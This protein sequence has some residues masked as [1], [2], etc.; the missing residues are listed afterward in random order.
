M[1]ARAKYSLFLLLLLSHVPISTSTRKTT[2]SSSRRRRRRRRK[3]LNEYN[4]CNSRIYRKRKTFV[5]KC[6]R[7]SF[8][9]HI[10]YETK[11]SRSQR[12]NRT[13]LLRLRRLQCE[14][15]GSVRCIISNSTIAAFRFYSRAAPVA[16]FSF[17]SHV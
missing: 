10:H 13:H 2:T 11:Q 1:G 7:N 17:P 3:T 9:H 5:S 15:L 14:M 6:K 16:H 12:A 8:D 4:N